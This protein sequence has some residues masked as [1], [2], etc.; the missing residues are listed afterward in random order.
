VDPR[1]KAS[2]SRVTVLER[3]LRYTLVEVRPETGRRH[4]IRAHLYSE[5]HALVGDNRY[6]DAPSPDENRLM[7]HAFRLG[8]PSLSFSAPSSIEAPVPESFR[9]ELSRLGLSLPRT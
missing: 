9:R 8:L 2:L 4:Q 3:A 1:G 7:L 5:G 6:G